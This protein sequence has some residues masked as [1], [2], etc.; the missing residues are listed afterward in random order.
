MTGYIE[1]LA[2]V[3][4]TPEAG[5]RM[6]RLFAVYRECGADA[7]WSMFAVTM[8]DGTTFAWLTERP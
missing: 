3:R 2:G 7:F 8:P 1:V 5:E 4:P 6:A